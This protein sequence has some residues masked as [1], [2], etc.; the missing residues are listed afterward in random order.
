MNKEFPKVID[1]EL[2]NHCDLNCRMC[3]RQL[4]T[5]KLG[6]MNINIFNKIIRKEGSK[7]V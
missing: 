6:Y 2:T 4:M 7:I 3:S 1:I 5:R